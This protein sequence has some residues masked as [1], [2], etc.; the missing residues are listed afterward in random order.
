PCSPPPDSWASP[1]PSFFLSNP[2]PA[3]PDHWN[4][5]VPAEGPADAPIVIVGLAPGLRGANRTGRPFVGDAS[6]AWVYTAMAAHG[7]LRDGVPA[8]VRVTNAVK[9]VPPKNLPTPAE[10]A[11][12]RERWLAAELAASPAGVFVALGAVA[13]AEIAAVAGARLAF[14]HGAEDVVPLGGRPRHVLAS[15]HPSPQNTHTRRLTAAMFD[16]VIARASGLVE[17]RG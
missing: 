8:G 7:L 17:G 12:C 11:T 1:L 14:A 4:R 13:H 16:A 6:G 3:A 10:R 5:P 15:Y 2:L 9:C